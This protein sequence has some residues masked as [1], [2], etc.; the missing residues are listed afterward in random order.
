MQIP[1]TFLYTLRKPE[2]TIIFM[3]IPKTAGTTFNIDMRQLASSMRLL[4]H[5][6]RQDE[7]DFHLL[8]QR[9]DILS[10]HVRFGLFAQHFDLGRAEC[11]TIVREPFAQ[12]HSHIKW[13]IQA[14]TGGGDQYA[15]YNWPTIFSL[16]QKLA[17]TDLSDARSITR[18]V[19]ECQD[20]EAV[21]LDNLQTRY[22]LDQQPLRVSESDLEQ[23][24]A[25]SA[26]FRLIGTTEA[27]TSFVTQFASLH[28]LRQ[29]DTARKMNRSKS[30]ALFAVADSAIQE[31]LLPLVRFDL[32]LY[33]YINRPDQ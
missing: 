29:P 28:G 13:L 15:R 6:E 17:A 9:Y 8:Q 3:H 11:Y 16:S 10:G 22:F 25:N 26:R 33:R 19:D 12:V 1:R 23:A 31:A 4:T 32:E 20:I 18:F 21:F 5:I 14:S 2:K 27:Y 7:A 30:P 24:K